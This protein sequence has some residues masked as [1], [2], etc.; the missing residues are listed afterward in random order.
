MT[1]SRFESLDSYY[2]GDIGG[3]F[4]IDIPSVRKRKYLH[5]FGLIVENLRSCLDS[6]RGS[7]RCIVASYS[8]ESRSYWG[9]MENKGRET[10][11]WS[12]LSLQQPSKE[13][14]QSTKATHQFR[15]VGDGWAGWAI[16]HR[17]FGRSVN[18]VSTR[19]CRLCPPHYWLPTQL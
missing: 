15:G 14:R 2:I 17:G 9:V 8:I 1:N 10:K 16:A 5:M 3:Y 19:G 12:L 4:Q 11:N 18:P 13:R 7:A 6:L